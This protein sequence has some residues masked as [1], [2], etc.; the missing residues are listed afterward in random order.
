MQ[1]FNFLVA[2][3]FKIGQP[4][5]NG[6]N[7]YFNHLC[8]FH[9]ISSSHHFHPQGCKSQMTTVY[10]SWLWHVAR[11]PTFPHS[12]GSSRR[13]KC[14]I[15]CHWCQAL[16]TRDLSC[17]SFLLISI[18]GESFVILCLKLI[19]IVYFW[20]H[21][22][23]ILPQI[24][25]LWHWTIAR[26]WIFLHNTFLECNLKCSSSE[27]FLEFYMENELNCDCLMSQTSHSVMFHKFEEPEFLSVF[28]LAF[29]GWYLQG[30]DQRDWRTVSSAI[31]STSF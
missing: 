5:T 23:E 18:V 26:F 15:T 1:H 20:I 25:I 9:P 27:S 11:Y 6:R 31:S 4:A 21:N 2:V 30:Q 3:T 8:R 17:N 22:F 7:Q 12:L 19:Q 24:E 14:L 29:K 10:S 16:N 13:Q 28:Q